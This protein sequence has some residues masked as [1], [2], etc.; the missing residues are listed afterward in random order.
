MAL[1]S[2]RLKEEEAAARRVELTLGTDDVVGVWLDETDTYIFEPEGGRV[3]V[4]LVFKKDDGERRVVF[5]RRGVD[6][7]G[8]ME[9]FFLGTFDPKNP[10]N[11]GAGIT[12]VDVLDEKHLTNESTFYILEVEGEV[13]N[14]GRL[15]LAD[16]NYRNEVK[17][18]GRK[19][20]TIY[21]ILAG[22]GVHE[23]YF[24]TGDET[25]HAL[26]VNSDLPIGEAFGQV[27]SPE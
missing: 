17:L 6:E 2:A 24:V 15:I 12:E 9:G 13:L 14:G 27:P 22:S 1:K 11:F 8:A 21:P 10:I 7:Y 25:S 19:F 18:K 20:K 3:T 4:R 5:A 16:D 23:I 26:R